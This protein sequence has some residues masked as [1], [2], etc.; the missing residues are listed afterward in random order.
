M[1]YAVVS[2]SI[3]SVLQ[4]AVSGRRGGFRPM[5]GDHIRGK[6]FGPTFPSPSGMKFCHEIL[7]TLNYITRKSL[8]RLV[9]QQY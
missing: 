4:F 9:L 7:E 8:S 1:A 5:E 3:N 6:G 2:L